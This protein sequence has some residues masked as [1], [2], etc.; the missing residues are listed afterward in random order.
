MTTA[1]RP[2]LKE[3]FSGGYNAEKLRAALA[4]GADPNER[5]GPDN[6][7]ALIHLAQRTFPERVA[8]MEILLQAG[9]DPNIKDG[10]AQ[11]VLHH[12]AASSVGFDHGT[13]IIALMV[14]YKADINA[15]DYKGDTPLHIACDNYLRGYN[16]KN[17][18]A[19]IDAG[20]DT[21]RK[22]SKGQTALETLIAAR[23]TAEEKE[24]ICAMFNK[25]ALR[26]SSAQKDQAQDRRAQLKE[27]AREKGKGFQLK[28]KP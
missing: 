12:A 5:M 16:T 7:P 9:A 1:R 20:A 24:S 19:V 26:I 21:A 3:A 8:L 2:T 28:K 17:L 25:Y 13:K 23:K 10:K 6:T 27:I 22:N 4:A 15:T 14:K 11:T 18:A